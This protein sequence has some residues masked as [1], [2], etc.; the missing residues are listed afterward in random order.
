MVAQLLKELSY[1]AQ[2]FWSNASIVL[3]FVFVECPLM[4]VM[5]VDKSAWFFLL[6]FQSIGGQLHFGVIATK[7]WRCR[8]CQKGLLQLGGMVNVCLLKDLYL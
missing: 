7:K 8:L 5:Y 6:H 3:A 1:L 2:G 4:H